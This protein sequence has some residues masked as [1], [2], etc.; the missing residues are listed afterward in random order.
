MNIPKLVLLDAVTHKEVILDL[1]AQA[2]YNLVC[3]S[4][5]LNDGV[6]IGGVLTLNDGMKVYA[7]KY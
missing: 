5:A 6:N 2:Y 7:K 1:D 3:D 4:L